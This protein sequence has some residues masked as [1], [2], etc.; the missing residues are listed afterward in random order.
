MPWGSRP[1][2]FPGRCAPELVQERDRRG[3]EPGRGAMN[4]SGLPIAAF[5]QEVRISVLHTTGFRFS[6]WRRELVVFPSRARR[7]PPG[8]APRGRPAVREGGR[9]QVPVLFCG[10][11]PGFPAWKQACFPRGS[12]GAACRLLDRVLYF[13]CGRQRTPLIPAGIRES[14]IW[15]RVRGAELPEPFPSDFPANGGS[16]PASKARERQSTWR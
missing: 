2:W 3:E 10:D 9:G 15:H 14:G 16:A 12:A 5:G 8:A 4:D 6:K 11:I 7:D 13:P 1:R